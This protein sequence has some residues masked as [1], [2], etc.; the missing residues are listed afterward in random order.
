[1]ILHYG[2]VC[3][4]FDIGLSVRRLR[5]LVC[6]SVCLYFVHLSLVILCC[7]N[8]FANFC[9]YLGDQL[10]R[11]IAFPVAHHCALYCFAVIQ[12]MLSCTVG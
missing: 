10:R 6:L 4:F 1:M 11:A 2:R 9:T 12:F 8:L 5:N 7:L 3:L